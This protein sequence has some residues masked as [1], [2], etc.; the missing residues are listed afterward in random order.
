MSTEDPVV[1]QATLRLSVLVLGRLR[2]SYDPEYYDS[3]R[4]AGFIAAVDG[5]VHQVGAC[6]AIARGE[7][8]VKSDTLIEH[9]TPTGLAF[10]DGTNLDVDSIVYGT[11][12][13]KDSRKFIAPIVGA[14]HAAA[15]EPVW[16]LD[17]HQ[18]I[19]PSPFHHR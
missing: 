18:Q 12:F 2:G 16:G 13:E 19:V 7:I 5:P 14:E 10:S 8:K 3:L 1:L 15:L 4:R 11:G 17:V 6:G 9:V